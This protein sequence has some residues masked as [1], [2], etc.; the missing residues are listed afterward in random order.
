MTYTFWYSGILIGETDFE[1][2][3]DDPRRLSGTFRPTAYG[4]E[5]FPRLTGVLSAG[6]ALKSLL[7]AKGLDPDE[8][9][10]DE[11]DELFETSEAAQKIVD[12]GRAISEV[13]T[14][15]PDGRRV[16]FKSIA[17]IDTLEIPRMLR[18]LTGEAHDA[19]EGLVDG[20]RYVVCGT[21]VDEVPGPVNRRLAG[22]RPPGKYSKDN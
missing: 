7:D 13:E 16:E 8:M 5:I 20:P 3:L 12:I 17:F 22:S 1:D 9:D 18:E 6:H 21:R 10:G 19:T 4:E 14:R 2:A 11:I 15:A